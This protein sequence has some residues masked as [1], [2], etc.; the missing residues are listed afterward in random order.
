MVDLLVKKRM[1]NSSGGAI[2]EHNYTQ[3]VAQPV[4]PDRTRTYGPDRWSRQIVRVMIDR[5]P[6]YE[7]GHEGAQQ[8]A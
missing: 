4:L 3:L 5:Q 1:P 8:C 6:G 2:F 7:A